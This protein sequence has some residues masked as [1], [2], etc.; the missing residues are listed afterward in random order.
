MKTIFITISRGGLIRNFFH[1][2]VVNMLLDKNFKVIILTPNYED[3]EFF[4][5]F[6]HE[7]LI[8][9][10]LIKP[11][12]IRGRK[13]IREFLKG[14]SFNETVNYLYKYKLDGIEPSKIFYIPRILF[15]APLRFIPGFKKFIRFLEFKI[16]PQKEHDYL[17]KKYNPDLVFATFAS[18]EVDAGVIKSAKRFRVKTVCIPKSWDNMSKSLFNTKTNYIIVWSEFMKN[19]AIK[20]QDYKD[21]EIIITGI[22]Q[23]DYYYKKENLMSREEFCKKFNFDPNKKIIMYGSNGVNKGV[24]YKYPELIKKFIDDKKLENV[25]VLVRPHLGYVGD[26]EQFQYLDNYENFAVDSNDKQ[27]NKFKDHWDTS[28]N[29]LNNLYNSLYHSDVC[30]NILSTLIFDATYCGTP[31]ISVKFDIDK[32][33]NLNKSVKRFYKTDYSDA[34]IKSGGVFVAESEEEFLKILQNILYNNKNN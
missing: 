19:Q 8:L 15:F 34:I 12:N 31:V 26:K 22:P 27:N 28:L 21:K 29:H 33:N 32:T 13:I 18:G 5:E 30:V 17:F 1:S 2:G 20:F 9:E 24:D 3:K 11:K 6:E 16:N 4:K 7:N 23:F 14:A 25:Q 10:P